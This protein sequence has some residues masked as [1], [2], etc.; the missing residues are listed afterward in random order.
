[1]GRFLRREAFPKKKVSERRE[2]SS[3]K[4]R[5]HVRKGRVE[6]FVASFKK[7]RRNS[8][9]KK[10]KRV[11]KDWGGGKNRRKKGTTVDRKIWSL[12]VEREKGSSRRK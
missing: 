1:V 10:R 2:T 6:K 11:Y 8:H 7:K 12:F 4:G 3:T 9:R 5:D